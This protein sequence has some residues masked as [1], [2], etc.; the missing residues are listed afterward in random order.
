[1]QPYFFPYIG[2]FQ[3]INAADEFVIYD[4]IEFTKKGW[5]NRN[6]I[7]VNGED[8]YITIPLRK[9][10]DFLNINQ[11]YLA[12]SWPKDKTKILNRIRETYK[13][14]PYYSSVISLIGECLDYQDLNLFNFILN[15]LQNTLQ[16]LKIHTPIIVSSTIPIDHH[17]LKAQEKVIEICKNRNAN[18]YLNPPGGVNL[19]NKTHFKNEN[20]NL[21]FLQPNS[22]E[23]A[24]FDHSFTPWLS[25][26][27]VLMFNSVDRVK[28]L[29]LDYKL[30]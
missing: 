8:V 1:M 22:I 19:Y 20:L 7:L 15:A 3:L 21:C 28:N 16:Y 2:Y 14:A 25:I 27:D 30:S 29:L 17:H 9:D 4:N 23:Y 13:K 24:Q 12:D 11:R 6:R 10:S 5:I 26:I 18:T